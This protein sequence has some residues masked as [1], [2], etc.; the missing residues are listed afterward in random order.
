MSDHGPPAP[1][2]VP[3]GQGTLDGAVWPPNLP[4][5]LAQ[6]EQAR[7][8]RGSRTIVLPALPPSMGALLDADRGPRGR[9]HQRHPVI[10]T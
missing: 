10:K 2:P 1:P 3:G 4:T 7:C 9:S 5:F 6:A 8:H